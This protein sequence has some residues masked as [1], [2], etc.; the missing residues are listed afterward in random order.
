MV[1]VGIVVP[2]ATPPANAES[3]NPETISKVGSPLTEFECESSP[4]WVRR[5]HGLLRGIEALQ[6]RLFIE[7]GGGEV[8]VACIRPTAA[9]LVTVARCRPKF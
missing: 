2:V 8:S 4:D 1:G 9:A 5:T 3:K 6:R 7:E